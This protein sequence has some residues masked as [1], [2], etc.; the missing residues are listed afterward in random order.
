M[1]S[2]NKHNNQLFPREIQRQ[3]RA[4][5]AACDYCLVY[6]LSEKSSGSQDEQRKLIDSQM[7]SKLST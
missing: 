6:T 7:V 3:P 1:F 2:N 4:T 5:P